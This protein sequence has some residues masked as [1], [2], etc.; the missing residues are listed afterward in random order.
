VRD[1]IL[2][3]NCP[4]ITKLANQLAESFQKD[5]SGMRHHPGREQL[6]EVENECVF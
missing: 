3:L 4:G 1:I 5:A 2:E 6:V